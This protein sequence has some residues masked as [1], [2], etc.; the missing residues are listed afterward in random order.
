MRLSGY[1]ND[2]TEPEFISLKHGT[3]YL[4]HHPDEPTMY[5]LK[6][7]FKLNYTPH[8]FFFKA[9]STE[10]KKSGILQFPPPILRCGSCTISF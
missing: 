8:Q 10:I 2:P 1:M 7:N 6:K 9:G 5:S 3:E 4:M